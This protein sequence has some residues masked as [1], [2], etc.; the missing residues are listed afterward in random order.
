MTT[1]KNQNRQLGGYKATLHNPHTGDPA[2][3]KAEDKLES[4]GVIVEKRPDHHHPHAH[5]LR[6]DDK[7]K[8]PAEGESEGEEDKKREDE[9]KERRVLGGYK[10]TL[11]NPHASPKAKEHA[12]Q[13]LAQRG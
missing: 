12:A 7:P 9:A 6:S 3:D 13:V 5:H 4:H 11:S 10:A 8:F 1:G 2:K